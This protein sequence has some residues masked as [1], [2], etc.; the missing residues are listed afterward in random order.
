MFLLYVSVEIE[1][2]QH[3]YFSTQTKLV[4]LGLVFVI[5]ITGTRSES[6][7]VW[8]VT[9]VLKAVFRLELRHIELDDIYQLFG[10][11]TIMAMT[12]Y[13]KQHTKLSNKKSPK[14]RSF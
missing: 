4:Y 9:G 5:M 11:N 10:I 1:P 13:S 8:S 7:V 3:R 12:K 2:F 6:T 14:L